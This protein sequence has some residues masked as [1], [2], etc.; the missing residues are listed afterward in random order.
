VFLRCQEESSPTLVGGCRSLRGSEWPQYGFLF[1]ET[2][3]HPATQVIIELNPDVA[4]LNLG[5][6]TGN[7]CG[8]SE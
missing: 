1:V 7:V 5:I 3:N 2:S 6:T 8:Y 4:A